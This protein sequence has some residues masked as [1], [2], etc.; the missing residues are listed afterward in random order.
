MNKNSKFRGLMDSIELDIAHNKIG[1]H[2]LYQIML[3]T[4]D[5]VEKDLAPQWVSVL[6]SKPKQCQ[7]VA[8]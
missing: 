7:C 6:N 8:V 4:L 1:V 2:G 3:E 5:A